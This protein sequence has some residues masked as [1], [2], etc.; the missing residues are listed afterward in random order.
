MVVRAS[1]QD[2]GEHPQ[3]GGRQ[4]RP[5]CPGPDER[6]AISSG[7][8]N[9]ADAVRAALLLLRGRDSGGGVTRCARR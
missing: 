9:L 7:Y 2:D 3:D 4:Q 8:R 6:H 5:E 1:A